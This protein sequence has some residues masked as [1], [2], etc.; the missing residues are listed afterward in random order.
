[1]FYIFINFETEN[2]EVIHFLMVKITKVYDFQV[3]IYWSILAE[4]CNIM[5]ISFSKFHA[6]RDY[7]IMLIMSS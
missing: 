1:M 3:N 4:K 6:L 5:K 2:F 7:G